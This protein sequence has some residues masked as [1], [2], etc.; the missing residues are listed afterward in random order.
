MNPLIYFMFLYIRLLLYISL[1][2]CEVFRY[3]SGCS[4]KIFLGKVGGYPL[5]YTEADTVFYWEGGGD[6]K[7]QT[8]HMQGY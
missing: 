2:N 1:N 8:R 7:G 6:I 5:H 4:Q 3:N